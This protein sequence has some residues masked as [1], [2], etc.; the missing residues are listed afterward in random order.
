[1]HDDKPLWVPSPERVANARITAFARAVAAQYTLDINSYDD[2]GRFSI[3]RPDAFW[4]S[5]W[6]FCGIRGDIGTRIVVDRR[7]A[8]EHV[9]SGLSSRRT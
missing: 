6:E 2:L 3:E 7:H 5:V 4:S 8:T 9:R 1:M